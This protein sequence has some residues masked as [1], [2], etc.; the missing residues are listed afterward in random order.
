MPSAAA[1]TELDSAIRRARASALARLEPPDALIL[2]ATGVGM[3][4]ER[5][6]DA[7]VLDARELD[8]APEAWA[9]SRIVGG[10]LGELSVWML[11][12][13]NPGLSGGPAWAGGFP[14]WLAASAGARVC[15]HTSAGRAL[16]GPRAAG[17]AVA[18]DHL[19]FGDANPLRGLGT[20]DLGPMFPDLSLLHDRELR[21]AATK[22]ASA[23]GLD[24]PAVVA[25]CTPG[26]SLLTPAEADMLAALGAGVSVQSLSAPLLAAGHA[27]VRVLALIA[28]TD[29]G[30][31]PIDLRVLLERAEALAPSLEDLVTALVP[32]LA[33]RVAALRTEEAP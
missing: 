1:P 21:G 20:N 18:S 33:R 30:E 7:A 26:P 5:L 31:R 4:P 32:D 12:D 6:T 3:L 23:L 27:G 28:V 8:G 17:L 29:P 13:E 9:G 25:A 11:D 10:R 24:L 2:A 22:R 15:V 16:A 19:R 14:V